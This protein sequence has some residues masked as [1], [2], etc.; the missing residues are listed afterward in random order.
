MSHTADDTRGPASAC[1]HP[2]LSC[3]GLFLDAMECCLI[4]RS[5]NAGPDG[6]PT[7]QDLTLDISLARESRSQ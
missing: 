5:P 3:L 6:N 4:T 2:I 1:S 7:T